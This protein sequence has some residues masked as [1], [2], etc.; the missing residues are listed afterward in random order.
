MAAAG[1]LVLVVDDD[2]SIRLLCRINLELGGYAVAEAETLAQA[3]AVLAEGGVRA[4]LLD[5]R[6]GADDGLALLRE[7]RAGGSDLPVALLTGRDGLDGEA[8]GLAHAILAK[9]F[10]LDELSS[11]VELLTARER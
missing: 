4:V 6:L 9:P 11:T 3:R 8:D 10:H 7:L 2:P 5:L 1:K